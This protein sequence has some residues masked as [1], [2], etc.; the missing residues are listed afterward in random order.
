M[1]A[2]IEKLRD[3]Q[4]SVALA[5]HQMDMA[6]SMATVRPCPLVEKSIAAY[7]AALDAANAV[8]KAMGEANDA[9]LAE[10]DAKIA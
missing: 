9:F 6:N 10:L 5:G 8:R 7:E 2:L 4:H 3:A 1:T